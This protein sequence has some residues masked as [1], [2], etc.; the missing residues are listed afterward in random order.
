MTLAQ[1]LEATG[2]SYA[3]FSAKIGAT[4]KHTVERYAKGERLPSPLFM[5]RI[6]AVTQ[7]KVTANDFFGIAA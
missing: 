1:Y 2:L 3:E 7:G 5:A 6:A 4:G